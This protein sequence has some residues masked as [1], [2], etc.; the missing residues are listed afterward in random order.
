MLDVAGGS[1]CILA[2]KIK[3]GRQLKQAADNS[4]ETKLLGNIAMQ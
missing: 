2:E 1:C 4:C 3:T